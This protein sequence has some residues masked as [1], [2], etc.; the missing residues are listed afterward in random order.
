MLQEGT[1]PTAQQVQA[2]DRSLFTPRF[3]AEAFNELASE[4][5]VYLIY[6][7]PAHLAVPVGVA[8]DFLDVIANGRNR[9]DVEADDN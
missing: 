5:D 6:Q 2:H 7:R 1:A 8:G 3:T 9:E 4:A